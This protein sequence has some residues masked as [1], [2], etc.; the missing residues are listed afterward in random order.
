MEK[1]KTEKQ[2]SIKDYVLEEGTLKPEPRR[3][4]AT[5]EVPK[6]EKKKVRYRVIVESGCDFVVE[7]KEAYKDPEQMAIIVSKGQFYI[8]S[9]DG[10]KKLLTKSGIWAFVKDLPSKGL[11][12][13]KVSWIGGLYPYRCFTRTLIDVFSD[14]DMLEFLQ[15]AP[16]FIPDA[17]INFE[18]LFSVGPHPYKGGDH[19][20]YQ[21]SYP[22][23]QR[24]NEEFRYS[25]F[26]ELDSF[27]TATLRDFLKV[28][29][30]FGH[31]DIFY[32]NEPLSGFVNNNFGDPFGD[33]LDPFDNRRPDVKSWVSNDFF[34]FHSPGVKCGPRELNAYN[35]PNI[36]WADEYTLSFDLSSKLRGPCWSSLLLVCK[37]LHD[38]SPSAY[39]DM[40]SLVMEKRGCNMRKAF[41]DYLFINGMPENLMFR[42]FHSFLLIRNAFG[43]EWGKKAMEM[44]LD[45]GIKELIPYDF[46]QKLLYK[47]KALEPIAME[48]YYRR[49]TPTWSFKAN[50]FLD[51]LFKASVKEGFGDDLEGFL[52]RWENVLHFQKLLYRKVREKYPE[53]LASLEHRLAYEIRQCGDNIYQALWNERVDETKHLEYTGK[54]YKIIAAKSNW[55]LIEE[56]ERQHNC[57][58]SYEAN[59]LSGRCMIFFMR[60]KDKAKKDESVL[61]IEVLPDG[62]LGQ[63]RGACNRAPKMEELSFV[64]E[65]AKKKKLKLD[66]DDVIAAGW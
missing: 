61:T 31:S 53:N 26:Y 37:L 58:H 52:A 54:E 65:W 47:E 34:T 17:Y 45:S 44:Y 33:D 55:D 28:E 46:L 41:S 51:Y 12:L 25:P 63:V 57:V 24:E 40:I 60:Y 49:L 48:G 35:G 4:K 2:V 30:P 62:T 59:V 20:I 15:K 42:S 38:S 14:K 19:Y 10:H 23:G 6:P 7:R 8:Q 36:I 21:C 64:K 29:D 27:G 39:R 22:G 11:A 66:E 9:A 5:A 18:D 50:C 3:K 13:P 56:S 43:P 1:T 16:F 32:N